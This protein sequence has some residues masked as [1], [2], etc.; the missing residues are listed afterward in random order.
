MDCYFLFISKQ[1]L[2]DVVW[3]FCMAQEEIWDGE[4]YTIDKRKYKSMHNLHLRQKNA[5][6]QHSFNLYPVQ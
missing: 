5:R 2:N 4:I 1:L 3:L 6:R